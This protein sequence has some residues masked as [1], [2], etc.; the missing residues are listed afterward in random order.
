MYL[1][2]MGTLSIFKLVTRSLVSFKMFRSLIYIFI[3]C[4][5]VKIRCEIGVDIEF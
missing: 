3:Y 2:M 4:I 1:D 5:L